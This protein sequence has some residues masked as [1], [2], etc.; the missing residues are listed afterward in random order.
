MKS[1][2]MPIDEALSVVKD[3]TRLML[4]GFIDAGSPLSSIEK[5]VEKKVK[6]LTLIAVTPGMS[7]FGKSML[8]KNKQVKELISTHVGTSAESTE[9]YLAGEL[10]IKEFF[11]MGTWIE[12]V[13]AG[14]MG[15]GGVLVP[16][17][18]GILD[19]VDLFPNLEEA[20]KVVEVSGVKCFIEPALTAEVSIVKAWRADTMGNLEFRGTSLNNN[21]DMAMAG[22]YTIAEVNEIVPV[23]TI[24]PER[25]GCPGVFVNAIVQGKK[26]DEQDELYKSVWLDRGKLVK[27]GD[28]DGHS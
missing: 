4:G 28:I 7:G 19:E 18:V 21:M 23:G 11:P 5:L 15:L 9:A 24:A 25:V 10:L 3:G 20:K 22:K 2:V 12:K 17:G 16:V 8:Y 26:I 6:N 13:R 27:E 1:K 14:A